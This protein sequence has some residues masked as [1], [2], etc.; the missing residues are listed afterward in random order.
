MHIT[1]NIYETCRN[2]KDTPVHVQYNYYMHT[3]NRLYSN[4]QRSVNVPTAVNKAGQSEDRPWSGR[5]AKLTSIALSKLASDTTC[6]YNFTLTHN[7][8]S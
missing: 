2:Y 6:M 8:S 5:S 3:N 4:I 1:H 7:D